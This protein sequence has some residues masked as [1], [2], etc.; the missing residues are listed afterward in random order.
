[1]LVDPVAAT[2]VEG[3]WLQLPTGRIAVL[4]AGADEVRVLDAATGA[5]VDQ[6]SVPPIDDG[7]LDFDP[8]DG[9]YW[10][11]LTEQHAVQQYSFEG[12]L[13]RTVGTLGVSGSG[14]QQFHS[15]RSVES[16]G[17]I[18]VADT[19]NDRVVAFWWDAA[20][21]LNWASGGSTGSGPGEFL[22]PWAATAD[23]RNRVLVADRGNARVQRMIL[24]DTD[25]DPL[26]FAPALLL[27]EVWFDDGVT[28][29]DLVDLVDPSGAVAV[30]G[31]PDAPM[32]RD[33]EGAA[34]AGLFALDRAAA[35][36]ARY[37]DD[38]CLG[39]P[40]VLVESAGGDLL[41]SPA[42]TGPTLDSMGGTVTVT[43]TDACGDPLVGFPRQDVWLDDEGSGTFT[44]CVQGT[45]A[46]ANSDG[47][48][49]LVFAGALAAGGS[50]DHGLRVV[51]LGSAIGSLLPFRVVSPDFDAD[52]VVDLVDI[53]AFAQSYGTAYDLRF[54]LNFDG[55]ISLPDIGEFARHLGEGCP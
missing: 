51:L 21:Q 52:L 50:T 16:Q 4:D 24:A 29:G 18:V 53:G 33:A 35:R 3:E 10:V 19:A 45:L 9:S 25:P 49:R 54:D 27:D 11:C 37:D 32:A 22:S 6:W 46:D 2:F 47:Q 38:C 31:L 14:T 15:P 44:P 48:G 34:V 13:L 23:C 1:V 28:F 30:V 8:S 42:G 40:V 12:D 17:Q 36:V 55:V 43:I 41:V 39:P 20:Q 26:V 7:D 5:L